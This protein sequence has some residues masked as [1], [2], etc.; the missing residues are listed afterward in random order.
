MCYGEICVVL[1]ELLC[2]KRVKIRIIVKIGSLVVCCSKI[3]V[4]DENYV[5]IK[6]KLFEFVI[7]VSVV[8]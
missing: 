1:N 2:N 5:I 4:C 8:V 7:F 3:L 6:I